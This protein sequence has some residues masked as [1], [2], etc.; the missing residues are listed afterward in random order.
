MKSVC[1]FL[2]EYLISVGY[3]CILILNFNFDICGLVFE[4]DCKVYEKL[5]KVIVLLYKD[6]VKKL[7]KFRL[8]IGKK[9]IWKFIVFRSFNGFVILMEDIERYG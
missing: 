8:I 9:K 4:E 3:G 6:F 2:S 7:F 5:G 1:R